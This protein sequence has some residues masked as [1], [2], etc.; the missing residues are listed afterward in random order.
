MMTTVV[1]WSPLCCC[2]FSLPTLLPADFFYEQA[3]QNKLVVVV[4]MIAPVDSQTSRDRE[5]GE[6]KET[7]QRERW[8]SGDWV[9]VSGG[10]TYD[11]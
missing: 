5:I 9:L 1:V 10:G 4:R 2:L 6:G 11:K 3:K 7:A 8:Q